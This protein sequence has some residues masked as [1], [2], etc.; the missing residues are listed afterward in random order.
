MKISRLFIILI[1]VVISVE[2]IGSLFGGNRVISGE[3]DND[4]EAVEQNMGNYIKATFGAGCFWGVEASFRQ[5]KGVIST[6]VG[7]TGGE[8]DNPTY[9]EVCTDTTGHA[10]AVEVT[11][12]PEK[13]SYAKL[14][15]IFWTGHNPTQFNRQGPDYGSQYRSVIFYHDDEQKLLAQKAKEELDASGEF[16]RP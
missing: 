4:K 5:I 1:A 11:Y 14:L 3:V 10:E 8:K 7:Y 16:N 13:V 12:D 15:E 2:L 9:K 6:R